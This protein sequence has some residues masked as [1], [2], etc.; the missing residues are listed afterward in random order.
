MGI[1]SATDCAYDDTRNFYC[2]GDK[3]RF[4]VC[5]LNINYEK[6]WTNV[7]EP[8]VDNGGTCQNGKCV[9]SNQEC[10][11]TSRRNFY[12]EDSTKLRYDSCINGEWNLGA[13]PCHLYGEICQNAKCVSPLVQCNG[14][15]LQI[16]GVNIDN[17]QVI[18]GRGIG[19]ADFK[20]TY[21]V[22]DGNI[23]ISV[24]GLQEL[25][26]RTFTL[27]EQAAYPL[28][29]NQEVR[30]D[31]VLY[32][33]TICESL[34]VLMN[35]PKECDYSQK[36]DDWCMGDYIYG[37]RCEA[38][39]WVDFIDLDCSYYDKTCQESPGS[40][41]YPAGEDIGCIEKGTVKNEAIE[42]EKV[43][44]PEKE[45]N[46]EEGADK[47]YDCSKEVKV[48]WCQCI[49]NSW[50]CI[51]SPES[52]CEKNTDE[53]SQN[54][55]IFP[56]SSRTEI[57]SKKVYCSISKIFENQ[58]AGWEKCDENYECKSNLC[59]EGECTNVE[60]LIQEASRW[61]TLWAKITCRIA[62]IFKIEDYKTCML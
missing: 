51:N 2:D 41:A 52:Q 45:K 16:E 3:A 23:A 25:E 48:V 6:D 58:K 40:N 35:S 47:Y 24:T 27:L 10:E 26:S 19:G 34:D 60:G 5:R 46:C 42:E 7:M 57:D 9:Y 39:Q 28:T 55:I 49:G 61:A 14:I 8:C 4:E 13:D 54:G 11:M 37:Q 33:G 44:P 36:K 29:N 21:L 22:L 30:V 62:D 15:N 20:F 32:D 12:C 43:L 18:I 38:G 50:I 53:C 59:L 56:T 17:Q 1:I 31:A